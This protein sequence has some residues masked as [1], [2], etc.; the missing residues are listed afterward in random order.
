MQYIKVTTEKGQIKYLS[1]CLIRY[2][3][4]AKN[5]GTFICTERTKR[6][7]RGTYVQEDIETVYAKIQESKKAYKK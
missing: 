3:I 5:G 4:Q 7:D 1:V 2:L 6:Y